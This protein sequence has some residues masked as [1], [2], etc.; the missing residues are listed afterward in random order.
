M[1]LLSNFE[2]REQIGY[3]IPMK[4]LV[5]ASFLSCCKRIAYL[6]NIG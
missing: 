1:L 3:Y 2:V 5:V 6:I 4:T